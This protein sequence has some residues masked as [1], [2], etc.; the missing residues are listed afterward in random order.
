M[1]IAQIKNLQRRLDHLSNEAAEELDKEC[2]NDLWRHLGFESVDR[3]ENS[4]KRAKANF[5]Y[6][7]WLT[8]REL[9]QSIG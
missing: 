2:G 4:T 5:Y 1:S 9:Q 8:V 7:Q 3:L 6:G